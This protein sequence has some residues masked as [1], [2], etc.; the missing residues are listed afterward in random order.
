VKT[1]SRTSLDASGQLIDC[2]RG[3]FERGVFSNRL[4]ARW[5][6]QSTNWLLFCVFSCERG[7]LGGRVFL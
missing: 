3:A 7:T 1:E 2:I 5:T 4:Y 6:S